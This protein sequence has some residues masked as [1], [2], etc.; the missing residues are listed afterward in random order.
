MQILVHHTWSCWV[1]VI[2]DIIIMEI[3]I[4]VNLHVVNIGAKPFETKHLYKIIDFFK[5]AAE[6]K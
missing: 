6:R 5:P 2:V 1:F 4:N 3:F